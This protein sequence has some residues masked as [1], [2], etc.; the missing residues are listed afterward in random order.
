MNKILA[1][2]VIA[3]ALSLSACGKFS[4]KDKGKKAEQ[5]S[6]AL[7]AT[8][9]SGCSKLDLLG[10]LS[11]KE[12]L[13]FSAVGDFQRTNRV[14]DNANCETEVGR[15]DTSGTYA[16]LGSSANTNDGTRDINLTLNTFDVTLS[17]D[18]SVKALN[19]AK[20]CGIDNWALNQ[21]VS[22]LGLDCAT[23]KVS[24]GDA[25]Y[26]IFRIDNNTLYFSDQLGVVGDRVAASRPEK[27][28]M[29]RPYV[30]K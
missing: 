21:R 14:Y 7:A 9:D 12:E 1:I 17:T 8:W 28:A 16:V 27:L 5:N 26:E 6:S 3:S 11:H 29:D 30:K 10:F 20:F 15:F 24:R 2:A 23:G 19:L 25:V 13:I 22:L 4:T 18:S